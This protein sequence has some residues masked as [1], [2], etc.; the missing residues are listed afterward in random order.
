MGYEFINQ[1]KRKKVGGGAKTLVSGSS[2]KKTTFLPHTVEDKLKIAGKRISK[3]I[4]GL[5][6]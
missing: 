3:A 6:D 5:L 2:K 1:T 4:S